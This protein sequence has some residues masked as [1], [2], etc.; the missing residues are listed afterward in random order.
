MHTTQLVRTEANTVNN[1]I[2]LHISEIL[3]EQSS[4]P[5]PKLLEG[6]VPCYPPLSSVPVNSYSASSDPLEI[7]PELSGG[8][9][10]PSLGNGK[11]F[12]GQKFLK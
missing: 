6:I 12:R 11:I 7:G 5:Q 10:A 3:G 4:V 2:F 1:Y 8:D 9:L